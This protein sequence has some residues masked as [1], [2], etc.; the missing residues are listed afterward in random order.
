MAVDFMKKKIFMAIGIILAAYILFVTAECVRLGNAYIEA[1]PIITVTSAESEN[2]S[3][4][5]GMGYSV[6]YYKDKQ[7][8]ADRNIVENIYGAE[9]RLFDKIMIWA[10]IE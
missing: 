3:K 7:L 1:K 9:F 8:N 4:Y 2:R 6:V 10:W 5:T